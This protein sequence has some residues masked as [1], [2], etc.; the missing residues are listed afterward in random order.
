MIKISEI[1]KKGIG[2]LMKWKT[3]E[4]IKYGKEAGYSWNDKYYFLAAYDN[5]KIVGFASIKIVGGVGYLEEIIVSKNYRRKE[6]G[7]MLLKKVEKIAKNKK[8]H[9]V[10][11][12]TGERYKT[13]VPFYI[14][15]GYKK[16]AVLKN[17]KFHD[18]WYFFEKNLK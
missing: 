1:R 3:K 11:L 7:L 2:K 17:N 13:A 8:C 12:S 18:K 16:V 10:Y 5:N 15:N 4:W 6:V 9:L 14:K